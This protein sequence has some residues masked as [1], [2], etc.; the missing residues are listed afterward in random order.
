MVYAL[1]NRTKSRDKLG[2]IFLLV[3][4][5][6]GS[7]RA[8]ATLDA[9]IGEAF[10]LVE[11]GDL[12]RA[13]PMFESIHRDFPVDPI[14]LN[15]V[16]RF[17]VSQQDYERSVE[18]LQQAVDRTRLDV[19]ERY[20][21]HQMELGKALGHLNRWDR[22]VTCYRSVLKVSPENLDARVN[23]AVALLYQKRPSPKEAISVLQ[24]VL[25]ADGENREF[26]ADVY[27]SIGVAFRLMNKNEDAVAAFDRSLSFYRLAEAES[28]LS[29]TLF[30]LSH[31]DKALFHARKAIE[32]EPNSAANYLR[33]G[34]QLEVS[35]KRDNALDAYKKAAELDPTSETTFE[36]LALLELEMGRWEGAEA[37]YSALLS[38]SPNRPLDRAFLGSVLQNQG[39]FDEAK[40][41]YEEAIRLKPRCAQAWLFL[42]VWHEERGE[43]E[44]AEAAFRKAMT[45]DP[46][47]VMGLSHLAELLKKDLSDADLASLERKV[48]ATTGAV[49]I[50]RARLLFAL[51]QLMDSR[52]TPPRVGELLEEAHAIKSRLLPVD[53][54]YVPESHTQFVNRSMLS[55][56]RSFFERLSQAPVRGARL[57][58]KPIFI[59]GMPRSGTTL[60]EQILSS[61]SQV[62]G[63]GELSLAENTFMTLPGFLGTSGTPTSVIS[64]LTPSHL[65]KLA[66]IYLARLN[67]IDHDRAFVV[68]KM[69]ENYLYLGL[70]VA[71]FPHATFL[72]ARRD[73]R[74]IALSLWITNFR[75][76]YWTHESSHVIHRFEEYSRIMTHW[77][78]VL[79]PS[80]IQEWSYE[81][82]VTG[83]EP[84]IQRLVVE[85]CGL[86][87]EPGCLNFHQ[88]SRVVKTK[89]LHQVR[90]PLYK[91]SL[92]RWSRYEKVRPEF[93]EQLRCLELVL[94]NSG[95]RRP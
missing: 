32:L 8:L 58:R 42:G 2:A 16:G 55:F 31:A 71:M 15:A 13:R 92:G 14:A 52:G 19:P 11:V 28:N 54:R 66:E 78:K 43:F 24:S 65:E 29:D 46:N 41:Q 37:A 63:A 36:A 26:F 57:S 73:F 35:G 70:L 85:A 82:M 86:T 62:H 69:P 80:L 5:S 33:L 68:D 34:H 10:R 84:A 9:R 50:Q 47:H 7:S 18:Y 56:D 95:K 60:L 21:V 81:D 74:D 25:L 48:A 45:F 75:T 1:G 77:Q 91:G 76:Q 40:I 89:S 83:G 44:L 22:C 12:D 64:E 51:A 20:V 6:L 88:T 23:L 94:S 93:F 39:R 38:L 4:L 67:A 61:H 27:N 17:Y 59:F 87:W 79:P 53:D 49:T 72:H 90:R 3:V 30:D